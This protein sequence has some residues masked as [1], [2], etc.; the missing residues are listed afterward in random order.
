MLGVPAGLD[1]ATGWRPGL[2]AT[3]PLISPVEG[4]RVEQFGSRY[5]AG[6]AADSVDWA[7]MSNIRSNDVVAPGGGA[8]AD[9]FN[10]DGINYFVTIDHGMGLFSSVGPI[11]N[12]AL[13]KG[14]RVEKGGALGTLGI[15][16]VRPHTLY[17]KVTLNGV[18]R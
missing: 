4:T 9:A 8:I 17:W 1:P 18:F 3:F 14:Q 16:T 5:A 2:D 15:D 10:N 6:N 12:F 11:R 13:E 7:V